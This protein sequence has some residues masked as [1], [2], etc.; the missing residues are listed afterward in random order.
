MTASSLQ[1]R[2]FTHFLHFF[3][4]HTLHSASALLTG[5]GLVFKPLKSQSS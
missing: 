1:P 5:Q 2:H 3:A 4:V